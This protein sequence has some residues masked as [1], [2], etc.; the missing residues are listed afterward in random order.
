MA[1]Y[2][3]FDTFVKDLGLAVHNLSTHSIKLYLSNT[4][5][6]GSGDAVKGD[7][8]EITQQNG[9]TATAIGS[10]TWTLSGITATLAGTD[11]T[12]TAS[13]GSFGPFQWV[14]MYND[15]P[16]SPADPLIAY[17]DYGSAIS[18]NTGES[19]TVDF[20]ASIATLA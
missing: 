19:F 6:T 8:L 11:V 4:S 12:W 10:L 18:V 14:I 17:W 5:P 7:C 3:K 1:A 16:T 15:T 20:G 2:V 9:Y 13:G